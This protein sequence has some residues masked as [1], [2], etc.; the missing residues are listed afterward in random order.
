MLDQ[1][2]TVGQ[3]E[4]YASNTVITTRGDPIKISLSGLDDFLE[5]TFEL[6]KDQNKNKNSDKYVDFS[7]YNNG[8]SAKF[9]LYELH[10]FP[11]TLRYTT[12]FGSFAK[13][14]IYLNFSATLV[15]KTSF[16]ISYNI[17]LGEVVPNG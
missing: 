7:V 6:S 11:M 4:L 8:T 2:V 1:K 12:E 10:E 13:R 14:R 3:L 16:E 15:G 9:K 5:I 17:F